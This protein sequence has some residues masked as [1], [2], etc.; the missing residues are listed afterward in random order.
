M[1]T[2]V[3]VRALLGCCA[4]L[5]LLRSQIKFFHRLAMRRIE[6]FVARP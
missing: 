6:S 2:V 1:R 3:G 5:D 4:R